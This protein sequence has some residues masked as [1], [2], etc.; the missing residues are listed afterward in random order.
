MYFIL[1]IFFLTQ[2]F[3]L[4]QQFLFWFWEFQPKINEIIGS[5]LEPKHSWFS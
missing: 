5:Q 4:E 2:K 3:D 1:Q